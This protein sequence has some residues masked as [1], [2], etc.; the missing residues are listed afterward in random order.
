MGK[1]TLKEI[2]ALAGVHKSTV[3]KVIHNRPGVSD[4]KRQQIRKLLDE[5]G[6]ESNP[7]AKAL[8]Y[9][10]KKMKI[11]VVLPQ[12][13][14]MPYLKRGMEQVQ[15][16]FNSFNIE[17]IYHETEGTDAI[18]QSRYLHR[19]SEQGVSGV[20]LLPI[21]DPLIVS[22]LNAL[23]D[24]KIPVVTVNS[25]LTDGPRLCHIEQNAK[26]S[27]ETAARMLSLLLPAGGE[28]GIISSRYVRAVKERENGFATY[29]YQLQDY[30]NY[31]RWPIC[32][33][34]DIQENPEDA[35]TKTLA[36]LD[37]HPD[38]KALFISCGCVSDI[39][40][41]VQ[42]KGLAGKLKIICY[43]RYPEIVELLKSGVISCTMNGH[44]FTQGR[45]SMRLL[46]EYLV[47]DRKPEQELYYTT[48]EILIRENVD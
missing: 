31:S 14:A 38:L 41:A 47:Y 4:A 21:E 33:V 18:A 11:A 39:C 19:L 28:V 9:Q 8:N 2:A 1:I 27:G 25:S 3:D 5:Y 17:V 35:Y 44:L 7:L 22:A 24:A 46:F 48:N 20:V 30:P 37:R 23:S 10:K 34:L 13:N 32:E 36:L 42:D 29:L 26:Q 40:R 15:Q 12:V 6:Y 43:E 16:D 45:L